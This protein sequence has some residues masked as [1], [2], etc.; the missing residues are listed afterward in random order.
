[1]T[2][3]SGRQI[4]S[5]MVAAGV[6][7]ALTAVCGAALL[8]PR[9]RP[10]LSRRARPGRGTIF[11]RKEKPAVTAARRLNC[12]AG[13]LAFSVLADSAIEHYRGSF[14]NPAMYVPLAVS[15]LALM[16][17]GHGIMDRR[18]TAH[19]IR[20]ASYGAALLTGAVGTGFHLYNVLKRPGGWR[21]ENLFYGAPLGAPSALLLSGLFGFMAERVRDARSGQRPRFLKLPIGRLTAALTA[22]G[23]LGTVGEA[24]L[25]HFRGAY[26]NPFMFVPV[27][28]PPGAALVMSEVALGPKRP[29]RAFSRWWL[30]LTAAI[31]FAGVAFHA[32]GVHRNMGGWRNWRQN[33][34]N[35][36]PLPAPPSFAGL[37]LAGLAAL[38]LREEARDA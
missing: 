17:S 19:R 10:A 29:R 9:R 36:P 23:L 35:G 26:H 1:M 5:D 18:A 34:L 20:D 25:L 11:R 13:V 31:G 38:S 6:G 27:T 2:I 32:Y 14:C 7:A 12:A 22:A 33:I 3:T 8:A 37:A 21:W 30:R 24:G 16:T 28:L 4:G 15:S